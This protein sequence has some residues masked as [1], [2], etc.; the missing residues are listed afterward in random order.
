MSN[1]WEFHRA[2]PRRNF[3]RR[4]AQPSRPAL[5]PST[6]RVEK[7]LVS[8][9]LRPCATPRPC[10]YCAELGRKSSEGEPAIS[11]E[12]KRYSRSPRKTTVR[13]SGAQMPHRHNGA[14]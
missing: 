7:I 1:R 4:L 8:D 5:P 6:Q 2:S 3:R 12:L 10:E 11:P 9:L 14:T 13:P